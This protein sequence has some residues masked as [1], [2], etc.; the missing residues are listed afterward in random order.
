MPPPGAGPAQW[1]VW[2]NLKAEVF[3]RLAARLRDLAAEAASYARAAREQA[4]DLR[5]RQS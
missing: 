3:D 1:I 4:S 5:A 2:L